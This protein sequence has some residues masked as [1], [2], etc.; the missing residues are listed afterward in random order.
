MIPRFEPSKQEHQAGLLS[1]E[2]IEE[3]ARL[4]RLNGCLVLDK[5]FPVDL[6]LEMREAFTVRY[7]SYFEP[8]KYDDALGVGNLRHMITPALSA[9]FNDPMFYANPFVR[10]IV[11]RT[12]GE[13][14]YV[15]NFTAVVS[16]PGA[17]MQHAHRDHPQLFNE[18]PVGFLPS[19]AVQMFV[20][21]VDLD[22]ATGTTRVWP[23]S[24]VKEEIVSDDPG[25]V[26]PHMEIGSCGL[27][28]Y[29]LLHRGLGNRSERV[30]PVL[31]VLYN[32][33]WFKDYWNHPLQPLLKLSEEEYGRIP[34]EHRWL[35]EWVEHDSTRDD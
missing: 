33:T 35:F 18:I 19:F 15:G 2:S 4:F 32:R 27:I 29:R 16:L 31:Y 23:R 3:A 7:S 9:P 24:H 20:P 30:R 13:K 8:K 26:D 22:D 34:E 14:Y 12:L 5:V 10:P 25:F 6:V 1:P 17:K 11:Q 21:L 28:D